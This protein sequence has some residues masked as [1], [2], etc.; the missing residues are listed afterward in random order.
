MAFHVRAMPKLGI[1]LPCRIS[2]RT[3]KE[4]EDFL[5]AEGR[6]RAMSGQSVSAVAR[7]MQD[8]AV[9]SARA[10]TNLMISA[11]IFNTAELRKLLQPKKTRRATDVHA[12]GGAESPKRRNGA[13]KPKKRK[14]KRAGRR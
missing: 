7:A 4:A 8:D 14:A 1:F 5:K 9:R 2:Y 13:T 3:T 12:A 11:P 10:Q 6:R